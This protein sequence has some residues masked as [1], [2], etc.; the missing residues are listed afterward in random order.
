MK[1][2]K[3]TSEGTN[4]TAIDLGMFDHLMDYSF[5]HSKLNREVKGKQL[6]GEIIK[7]TA[8]EI[9]FQ[10]L[11]PGTEIQFIHQHREHEEIYVFLKGS[12]QFQVDGSV[13]DV[14]EGSVIRISPEGKRTYRNNSEK[15][16]VF[17]CIQCQAGSLNSFFIEDGFR[18]EGVISWPK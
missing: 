16:L 2:V 18:A 1:K 12:G 17:M 8:S 9:S 4:Y 15:P 5:L 10:L 6:I 11:P 7:S 14:S 3:I 13:F